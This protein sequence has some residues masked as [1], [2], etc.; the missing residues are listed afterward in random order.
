M[1]RISPGDDLPLVREQRARHGHD[2]DH[3]ASENA[4]REVT[5]EETFAKSHAV[6]SPPSGVKG[7]G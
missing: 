1:A 7:C 2:R 4:G 6:T 5:P 3:D